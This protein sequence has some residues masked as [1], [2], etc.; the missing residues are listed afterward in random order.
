MKHLLTS[1]LLLC[2]LIASAADNYLV[3]TDGTTYPID[4][5]ADFEST[6]HSTPEENAGDDYS[7][8]SNSETVTVER[9]SVKS[10]TLEIPLTRASTENEFYFCAYLFYNCTNLT[11]AN[12][13]FGNGDECTSVNEGFCA[14]MFEGC[15]SLASLPGFNLPQSIE[16]VGGGFGIDMFYGCSSLVSLHDNFNLPEK[17]TG[18]VGGMFCFAMFYGCSS[19][20][21]LPD[22]FNIPQGITAVDYFFSA[23]MFSGCSSLVSLPDKFNIPSN[24]EFSGGT[25]SYMFCYKM[26]YGCSKLSEGETVALTFPI[27]VT[28][29]FNDTRVSTESSTA[30]DTIY[31]KGNSDIFTVNGLTYG[32]TSHAD[33]YVEI[34]DFTCDESVTIPAEITNDNGNNSGEYTVTS[35]AYNA[36]AD[37]TSLEKVIVTATDPIDFEDDAFTSIPETAILYVPKGSGETY[38]QSDW[39][40]YFSNIYDFFRVGDTFMAGSFIYEVLSIDDDEEIYT[41][42]VKG[43]AENDEHQDTAFIP[44]EVEYE[45]YDQSAITFTVTKIEGEA[46]KDQKS[47]ESLTI[48]ATITEIGDQA[49]AGCTSLTTVSVFWEEPL[50]IN[51]GTFEQDVEGATLYVPEGSERAYAQSGWHDYFLIYGYVEVGD[52]FVVDN[53]EYE[54]TNITDEYEVQIIGTTATEEDTIEFVTEVE[55]N[56]FT[57]NVV[58]IADD[59]FNEKTDLDAQINIIDPE[60]ITLEEIAKNTVGTL[61]VYPGTV[62][63]YE[64]SDWAKYFEIAGDTCYYYGG[65]YYV[66]QIEGRNKATSSKNTITLEVDHVDENATEVTIPRTIDLGDDSSTSYEVTSMNADALKDCKDLVTVNLEASI[67][68]ENI[69]AL[70][71]VPESVT[72]ILDEEKLGTEYCESVMV[73]ATVAGISVKMATTG[74]VEVE[75]ATEKVEVER[76]NLLGQRVDAPVRGIN[77]V[78]YSDGSVEKVLVK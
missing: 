18:N 71:Q 45:Y 7:F 11:E 55:F 35:I 25:D 29:A 61:T 40:N 75:L 39:N 37:C 14:Y 43:F 15:T 53:I 42:T 8:T 49:F 16:T 77:I 70:N 52:T 69:E 38:A 22:N 32:I 23:V 58:N 28:D 2:G 48:P 34:I 73:A 19:L 30:N 31:L 65:V 74:I 3:T 21:S 62:K 47:L 17:I 72:I 60:V 9:A 44:E 68:V 78:K 46:F 64:A 54:I 1:L 27:E 10:I 50:A 26:F 63:M 36:F 66:F 5:P 51:E 24:I 6:N 12:I 59:A 13:T 56:T 57:F 41:L 20:V 4:N 67:P 76:Y 33:N